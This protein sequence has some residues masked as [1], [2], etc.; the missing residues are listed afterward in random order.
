MAKEKTT[1]FFPL[2]ASVLTVAATLWLAAGTALGAQLAGHLGALDAHHDDLVGAI[3]PGCHGAGHAR[4][5][6]FAPDLVEHLGGFGA[7][8]FAV[9]GG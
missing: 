3:E 8:A 6:G 4:H 7:D 9:A 2:R 1:Q 5:R